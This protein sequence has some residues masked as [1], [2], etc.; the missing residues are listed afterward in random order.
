MTISSRARLESID[1]ALWR[2]REELGQ[3]WIGAVR[4][5]VD[6]DLFSGVPQTTWLDLKERMW[7]RPDNYGD[8]GFKLTGAGLNRC[9]ARGRRTAI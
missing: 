2:M 5:A 4:F 3:L 9:D 7:I 6:D 8:L 1:T